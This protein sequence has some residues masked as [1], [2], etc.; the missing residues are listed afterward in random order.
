MFTD[1]A[2]SKDNSMIDFDEDVKLRVHTFLHKQFGHSKR[3]TDTDRKY[4]KT[5]LS[6]QIQMERQRTFTMS[7]QSSRSTTSLMRDT[8][9]KCCGTS[10]DLDLHYTAH[11]KEIES[12]HEQLTNLLEQFCNKWEQYKTLNSDHEHHFRTTHLHTHSKHYRVRTVLLEVEI[13]MDNMKNMEKDIME[14]NQELEREQNESEKLFAEL[15]DSGTT[16]SRLE[17]SLKRLEQSLKQQRTITKDQAIEKERLSDEIR[18]LR[19]QVEHLEKQGIEDQERLEMFENLPD[20]E[21]NVAG[22]KQKFKRAALKN[23]SFR[24]STENLSKAPKNQVTNK[25]SS[26]PCMAIQGSPV[27]VK[28]D[29]KRKT[30]IKRKDKKKQE[31]KT[32]CVHDDTVEEGNC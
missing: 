4:L 30:H 27:H 8:D 21:Q 32:V 20:V 19:N 28:P 1:H 5:W 23:K 22:T 2:I 11:R 14:K 17:Q 31:T 26:N 3:I 12:D 16:I 29:I 24:G 13:L 7:S 18:E 6:M 10:D 9:D 15:Y 25:Y